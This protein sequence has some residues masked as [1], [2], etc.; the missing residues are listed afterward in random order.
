MSL[1]VKVQNTIEM[2]EGFQN[3]V[4]LSITDNEYGTHYWISFNSIEDHFLLST[5]GNVSFYTTKRTGRTRFSGG[6][7]YPSL[8]RIQKFKTYSDMRITIDV[9]TRQKERSDAAR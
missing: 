8:G 9:Y 6:Q 5:M 4:A 3:T 1:P 2:I 7:L